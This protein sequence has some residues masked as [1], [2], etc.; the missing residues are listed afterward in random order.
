MLRNLCASGGLLV[1]LFIGWSFLFLAPVW[2]NSGL[3]AG[4][5]SPAA[6][7]QAAALNREVEELYRFVEAGNIEKAKNALRNVQA[8]FEASSFQGLTTVEGIQ[9]LAESIVE[10]KE[11][12]ARVYVDPVEWMKAAGKLRLA[13]DSLTHQKNGIWLQY[14]KVLREDL[15]RMD[16]SAAK[17]D[18]EGIKKAY[19]S[20]QQHYEMIR[21]A[22]IIRRKP[23]EIAMMDSWLSYAGSVVSKSDMS[24][25]KGI[26]GQG[27]V[28]I[29]L[30]FGKK[31]DE[32]ALAPLGEARGPWAGQLLLPA[33]I[34]AALSYAGYR[35]Y[36]GQQEQP[37]SWFP[38]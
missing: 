11:T 35:K 30:L 37:I 24:S 34:L 10:M 8:L 6:N 26:T 36:K 23:D 16:Q 9:V 32:P 12:A 31:K 38:K 29:N 1:A 27:E 33:F 18:R 25:V 14:Y 2:A 19:G 22:A 28:I 17:Q 5:T 7:I 13:A 21:P 3:T 15:Q 20:L 4:E